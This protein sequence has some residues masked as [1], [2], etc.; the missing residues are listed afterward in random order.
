MYNKY[1]RQTF[2]FTLNIFL[3]CNIHSIFPSSFSKCINRT[4][5]ICF[6]DKFSFQILNENDQFYSF[7]KDNEI[8]N[9][10]KIPQILYD[11]FTTIKKIKYLNES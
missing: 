4:L 3:F 10:F 5:R 8:K 1:R 9:N 7:H 6:N 2:L 11:K